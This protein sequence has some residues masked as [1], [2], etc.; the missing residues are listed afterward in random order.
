MGAPLGRKLGVLRGIASAILSHMNLHCSDRADSEHLWLEAREITSRL[1]SV[2]LADVAPRDI[3]AEQ[4][5]REHLETEGIEMEMNEEVEEKK[6]MEGLE[7]MLAKLTAGADSGKQEL[8]RLS[9]DDVRLL[10]DRLGHLVE[11]IG[12]NGGDNLLMTVE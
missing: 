6:N 3:E 2:R 10:E 4:H 12:F 7:D 8:E 11:N 5:A 9:I 1:A